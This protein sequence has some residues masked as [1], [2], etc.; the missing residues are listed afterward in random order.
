MTGEE[1]AKSAGTEGGR[2]ILVEPWILQ[3]RSFCGREG[4]WWEVGKQIGWRAQYGSG[5][6]CHGDCPIEC[7]AKALEFENEVRS[8][9]DDRG[10]CEAR[11]ADTTDAERNRRGNR[12]KAG[13]IG[14]LFEGDDSQD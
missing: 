1:L 11:A 4:K 5:T 6:L 7:V 8:T 9:P 2:M 13:T 10:T 14:T 12:G 3:Q